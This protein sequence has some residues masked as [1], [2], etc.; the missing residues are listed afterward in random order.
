VAQT[1]FL[2][3][4]IASRYRPDA[5]LTLVDAKHAMGQLDAR[6]GRPQQ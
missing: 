6:R 2:D 1:F 3:E 4:A 5:I